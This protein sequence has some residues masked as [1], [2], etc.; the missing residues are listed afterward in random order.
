MKNKQRG[1]AGAVF[2]FWI[3]M[4]VLSVILGAWLWPYTLNTWLEFFGKAPVVVWWHGVIL[5]LIPFTAPATIP[6]AVITWI[7]MLFLG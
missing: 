2:I 3:F 1:E 7:L 5:S 4:L 6:A